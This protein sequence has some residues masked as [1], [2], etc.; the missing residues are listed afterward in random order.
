L[1]AWVVY[2]I[3]IGTKTRLQVRRRYNIDGTCCGDSCMDDCCCFFWC[4]CCTT[5]QMARHT[6][7]EKFYPYK[8]DRPTGLEPEAPEIV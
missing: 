2:F 5:I 1:V 3:I 4:T 8:F 6:H 7:D